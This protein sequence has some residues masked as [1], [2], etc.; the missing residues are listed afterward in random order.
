MSSP[1]RVVASSDEAEDVRRANTSRAYASAA[2]AMSP[3]EKMRS[4]AAAVMLLDDERRHA[5]ADVKLEVAR[6]DGHAIVAADER[7]AGHG[8]AEGDRA[9]LAWLER[10]LLE[11]AQAA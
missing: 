8:N 7:E 2:P 5:T 3:A 9:S 4:I 1:S 10:D 6:L 11:V